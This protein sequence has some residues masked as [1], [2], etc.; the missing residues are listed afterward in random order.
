MKWYRLLL[1]RCPKCG[2]LLKF[3]TNEEMI[4]CGDLG[5]GFQISQYRM[6]RLVMQM[7]NKK[8]FDEEIKDY[9]TT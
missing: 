3:N 7:N 8:P 1:N 4:F 5:C 9:E 6:E 2:K